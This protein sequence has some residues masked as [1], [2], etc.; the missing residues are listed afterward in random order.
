MKFAENV[1]G[2]VEEFSG[3]G[4]REFVP[5]FKT[6]K[7]ICVMWSKIQCCGVIQVIV[8]RES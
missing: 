6:I 3:F 1:L 8:K 5:I 4:F 2:E 7:E